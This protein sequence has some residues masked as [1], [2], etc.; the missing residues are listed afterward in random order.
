MA[1]ANCPLRNSRNLSI[2]IHRIA[3]STHP[4][5]RKLDIELPVGYPVRTKSDDSRPDNSPHAR[6]RADHQPVTE[7]QTADCEPI[8]AG[9]LQAASLLCTYWTSISTV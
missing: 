7:N 4:I 1:R 5:T 9:R 8:A 6:L 2:Q 3:W